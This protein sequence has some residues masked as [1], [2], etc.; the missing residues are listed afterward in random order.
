MGHLESNLYFSKIFP[1]PKAASIWHIDFFRIFKSLK[2]EPRNVVYK[3]PIG[4]A[5]MI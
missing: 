5:T 3:N 4:G 2:M 1:K